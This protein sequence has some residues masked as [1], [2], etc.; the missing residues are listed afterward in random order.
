MKCAVR[1]VEKIRAEMANVEAVK[2]NP[3]SSNTT[4]P[5]LP[6]DKNNN[7][8]VTTIQ[9]HPEFKKMDDPAQPSEV[10]LDISQ[11]Q[12]SSPPN[13]LEVSVTTQHMVTDY[14][15]QNSIIDGLTS[16]TPEVSHEVTKPSHVH[17]VYLISHD[18]RKYK[19]MDLTNSEDAVS[20]S[21]ANSE[22]DTNTQRDTTGHNSFHSSDRVIVN[23]KLPT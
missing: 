14:I 9:V 11:P 8:D 7:S 2:Q 5:A 21:S 22:S 4:A 12:A 3:L 6:D 15:S 23:D 20:S 18:P 13:S 17:A 19:S 1:E 16:D 10:P